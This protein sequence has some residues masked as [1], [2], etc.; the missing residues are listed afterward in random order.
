MRVENDE[1]F[2][3]SDLNEILGIHLKCKSTGKILLKLDDLNFYL[4]FFGSLML[5]SAALGS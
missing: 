1:K 3:F 5:F 4:Y 2:K